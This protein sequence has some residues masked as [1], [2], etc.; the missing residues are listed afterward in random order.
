MPFGYPQRSRNFLTTL[1]MIALLGGCSHASLYDDGLD[2]MAS[3]NKVQGLASLEKATRDDPRNAEKRAAFIRHRDETIGAYLAEADSLVASGQSDAAAAVYQRV[4]AIDSRNARAQMGLDRIVTDRRNVAHLSLAEQLLS[5]GDLSSAERTVRT[6]RA[7][8][9]KNTKAARLQQ[10]IDDQRAKEL[11]P[12]A[13]AAVKAALAKP[14]A[15]EFRDATLKSVFEVLSRSSGLNFVFDKDVKGDTK[16]TFF[17][18][19]SPL[20]DI[21]QLILTTNQLGKR[22]LN[23]NSFLI[24]PNTAP[25][26]KEYQELVVRS[27]Y[28]VN[29]DVKQAQA[30]VKNIAKSKDVF[31]DE[32]LNLLIVKDTPEAIAL[33]ERLID[34][35][36]LSEPEVMLEVEVL[37]VT[38][39]RIQSLGIEWPTYVG[40]GQLLSD[41]TTTTIVNGVTQSVTTPGG[42]LA[43]GFVDTRNTSALTT[44]VANPAF[45]ANINAQNGDTNLLANPRIRVKNREKAKIHIGERLPV[46]TTTSTANVGVS[47]SVSYLDIGLKLDVETNITLDDDVSMKVGLE[48]S[49]VVKE[50]TGPQSSLA[51]QVGTRS[52]AT[53]LRLKDGE[54]Q[55]LAGLIS[56]EERKATSHLPGLG[57][58]P[59]FGRL[60]GTQRDTNIKTEIILLITPRVIRNIHRPEVAQPAWPSGTESAIGAA[61]LRVKPTPSK[62]LGMSTRGTGGAT[63]ASRDAAET[64]Q[65]AAEAEAKGNA[66]EPAKEANANDAPAAGIKISGPN[67]AAS[68]SDI[69]VSISLPPQDGPVRLEIAYDPTLFEAIQPAAASSGRITLSATGGQASLRLRALPGAKGESNITVTSA[70]AENGGAQLEAGAAHAVR[71][72]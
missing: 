39:S 30:V 3:G 21:L 32:K 29:T 31:A 11:N 24:Y 13:N 52:T 19:N 12:V 49:N 58:I 55:V 63:Q 51:Y 15:L 47:A 9:P 66:E 18:R 34:S 2:A 25:K 67:E 22:Q 35:I 10:Q 50:V 27:F 60:F 28:L 54:T 36:D 17:V 65:A 20:E 62:A 37:E 57:D 56:D 33:V 41:S 40:Y 6:V 61:P 43:T 4:L 26:A 72:N 16:V 8:D 7:Q 42:S 23:D 14:V 45:K 53:T 70:T 5:K 59:A 38:R 71:L 48:V 69:D 1:L 44:F 46:F 68:G 64:V